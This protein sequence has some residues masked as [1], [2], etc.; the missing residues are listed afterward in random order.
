MEGDLCKIVRMHTFVLMLQALASILFVISSNSVIAD[1][2]DRAPIRVRPEVGLPTAVSSFALSRD[3]RLLVVGG[4][5]YVGVIDLQSGREVGKLSVEGNVEAV[6]FG[7]SSTTVVSLALERLRVHDWTTGEVI[8]E[9]VDVTSSSTI[10]DGRILIIRSHRLIEL[11]DVTTGQAIW[12]HK[13]DQRYKAVR[14]MALSSGGKRVALLLRDGTILCLDATN[15]SLVAEWK[16]PPNDRALTLGPDGS[17]IGII[18]ESRTARVFRLSDGAALSSFSGEAEKPSATALSFSSDSKRI[19]VGWYA[20]PIA[21]AGGGRVTVLDAESS[22]VLGRA[23]L[24]LLR[25]TA[26]QFTHDGDQL[27]VGSSHWQV[28]EWNLSTESVRRLGY[29]RAT[30]LFAAAS[31][32]DGRLLATVSRTQALQVWD[33]AAGRRVRQ[34]DFRND[35]NPL[36]TVAWSHN[37]R[38]IAVGDTDGNISIVDAQTGGIQS[39]LNSGARVSRVEFSP[40][41]GRLLSVHDGRARVWSYPAG[42]VIRDIVGLNKRHPVAAISPDAKLIATVMEDQSVILQEID[43]GITIRTLPALSRAVPDGNRTQIQQF[44]IA[45][46]AFRPDG[47][48]LALAGYFYRINPYVEGETLLRLW[49]FNR[50]NALEEI[51]NP[52]GKKSIFARARG[53][54]VT[55]FIRGLAWNSDGSLL[56]IAGQQSFKALAFRGGDIHIAATGAVEA[57]IHGA[58]ILPWNN[59]IAILDDSGQVYLRRAVGN[60]ELGR[61]IQLKDGGWVALTPEGYFDASSFSAA[62]S[63][64][65]VRGTQAWG[66]NEFWEVF[67]RPDLVRNRFRDG[68]P[69]SDSGSLTFE[70][71]LRRPPPQVLRLTPIGKVSTESRTVKLGIEVEDAGGGIGEVRIALNGKLVAR[72]RPMAEQG[73]RQTAGQSATS[74]QGI[75]ELATGAH[76]CQGVVEIRLV[77]GVDNEV[78]LLAFNADNSIQ[79][80]PLI[81]KVRSAMPAEPARLWIVAVGIDKF[82]KRQ[83][84]FGRLLT[85]AKD[86]RDFASALSHDAIDLFGND[87]IRPQSPHQQLLTDTDATREAILGRLDRVAAEAK[88][89]D[90]V[91]WFFSSHGTLDGTGRFAV[92]PHDINCSDPACRSFTNLV[93]SE[94]LM[95]SIQRV[96]AQHQLLILDTCH[97]G[98]IDDNVSG[99]YDARLSVLARS[100]G[101]HVFAGAQATEFAADGDADGN[102]V[103]TTQ[104]LAGF[105]DRS[106][107]Q[108][109]DGLLS[110]AELGHYA[111]SHLIG[112]SP[113]IG[114]AEDIQRIIR[115]GN[116]TA[117]KSRRQT[118][119]LMIVGRDFGLVRLQATAA[120][121]RAQ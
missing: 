71:A 41:S 54:G 29:G 100:M 50:K 25:P 14:R 55:D 48:A 59:A 40:D 116:P 60:E 101:L 53:T 32:P 1:A 24:G 67:Y 77:P 7:P 95:A 42:L 82:N 90:T 96:P 30:S 75:C 113:S 47:R 117:D 34:V 35:K 16:R 64:S 88:P 102:G 9:T 5:D 56:L 33:L 38:W 83:H 44:V 15:D 69:A 74:D 76:Q 20:G 72:Q 80:Q 106:A 39:V 37:G 6:G 110:S 63:I 89:Q 27:L 26:L 57:E 118:P 18:D 65:I 52:T 94:D 103:F 81:W 2:P 3:G 108:N 61:L 8:R 111:R 43:T 109:A 93:S 45:Q 19:A 73:I 114:D 87:R 115:N 119:V 78:A 85:A 11:I 112:D 79:S 13:L 31:S 91:V 21:D 10:S 107:D 17:L 46:L 66:M 98:A 62:D 12:T 92:V 68:T 86:A 84:I 28:D 51:W 104:I 70:D 121:S 97:A 49:S 23:K 58:L 105:R 120:G 36:P 4:H 22:R 99:L